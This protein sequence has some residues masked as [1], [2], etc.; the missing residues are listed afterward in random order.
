MKSLDINEKSNVAYC[1][2]TSLR[3]E[4]IKINITKVSERIQPHSAPRED[5]IAIV[6]YG[7]SL[8]DTW[9]EIKKFKYIMTCSGAHKFLIDRGIIPTWH[10]DLEPREYKVK[11]L[12]KPHSDV[13]YLIA[14]TVHPG[15][16]DA[17]AGYNVKLWHIFAN[18]GDAAS[19]LPRGE[20][21]VTGGCIHNLGKV[22]TEDGIKTIKQIVD[23]GYRGRVLSLNKDGKFVWSKILNGIVRRN[24]NP[25]KEWVRLITSTSKFKQ[26]LVC[27]FDHRCA[28]ID[29][30]LNPK[31]YYLEANK[32][33]GKYSVRLPD[34]QL[35][36]N[37]Q[38]P[39]YNNEQMSIMFGIMMG[40]GDIT[41]SY[42]FRT[43]HGY[44]QRDYL[45]LIHNIFGGKISEHISGFSKTPLT[46]LTSPANEQTKIL[47]ELF[48]PNNEIK[49]IKN[50]LQYLDEKSL[51]FWYMDDG[52]LNIPKSVHGHP[53]RG[54]IAKLCTQGFGEKDNIILSRYFKDR[55]GIKCSVSSYKRKEKNKREYFLTLSVD[56]SKRLFDLI[57]KYVPESMQY[58]LP[59]KHRVPFIYKFNNKK[60][61][62]A[63]SFIHDVKKLSNSKQKS[64][65]L[66]DLEVEETHSFVVNKTVVHNSSVGLRCM[67]LSR[68]LG[69]KDMH[70]FGMD[71]NFKEGGS[72]HTA[73]HPNAPKKE[74]FFIT[75]YKGHIYFTNPSLLHCAKETFH[76][77]NQMPDVKATFYGEGLTQAMAKDYVRTV[78]KN[79]PL[80]AF[81][82]PE[83]ISDEYRDLNRK[84]HMSNPTYG[85]GGSKHKDTILKLSKQLNTTSILDY[86]CGKGMLAKELQFPIWEYD[87]AVPEKSAEPK[88]ADIVVCTDVL[89][90]IEEDKLMFVLSD[91]K[92]CVKQVGYFVISTRKA[93]KTYANGKN[94][95]NIVKG[96]DWWNKQLGKY[97]DI[98]TIIE[99][100][101]ELQ[102][103]VGI[104]TK[105]T[106]VQ[107]NQIKE[108]EYQGEKVK[109]N[110]PNKTIEWRVD[111]LFKK[112]PITIEWLKSL[113]KGEILI[114]VGA[115]MG[116]YSMLASKAGVKVFAFEPEAENYALL[117]KNIVL[118]ES[119]AI[120]Y[121]A[122]VS[123]KTGVSKLS[124]SQ[125][126]VGGSCHTF[127]VDGKYN[128]G[129]VGLRLDDLN[130][131]AD[132]IK[133]DVDG[134]EP[135]VVAGAIKLLS[136]G[137]KSVLMEV[138]TNLQSHLAMIEVMKGMGYVYDQSQ[139]DAAIR[140]DGPFKGCAEYLF[141]KIVSAP[142]SDHIVN[143][144][145]NTV[146]ETEPFKYLYVENV[147]PMDVYEEI[148]KN[149]PEGEYM[150]IEKT[151][152]TRGYPKRF[153]AIPESPFWLNLNRQLKK[154]GILDRCLL[155]RF[156]IGYSEKYLIDL[157]LIRDEPGYSIPPHTDSLNKV[158]TVLF[159][160]PKDEGLIDEGTSLFTPKTKYFV[161]DTGKHYS[162]DD[163]DKVKTVMFKPN[164][165]LAFARTNDSF[166]GVEPTKS[167]RDVLLYN[168]NKTK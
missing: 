42:N 101:D 23:S 39:M 73:E 162:F 60:L 168:I 98:G 46:R 121:C 67:T 16:L 2:P 85:M 4:Q 82:K 65:N 141:K 166:H 26:K 153:T 55:W 92:R 28:V 138:N 102:I 93:V 5:S 61:D 19:V 136:N 95:H 75:E 45:D 14:S 12:G 125:L 117:Q 70:I 79:E 118:N 11:L 143:R 22:E 41:K 163:F 27:T 49:T 18:E 152:G 123:D 104:K 107:V 111:T 122:A 72:T 15:Y 103:V 36:G 151:R 37:R 150:E 113:K 13:E 159:Y 108:V 132:H 135:Q 7:P 24:D 56:G 130:I 156:G 29:N 133:I 127:G 6:C 64:S 134:C 97:F 43:V 32:T 78:I 86:G 99:K 87:P 44:K 25:R 167:V 76:E 21:T 84:L 9:E 81:E 129:C 89:E 51:A 30:I 114:D 10:V 1:I 74:N 58:K 161:C 157:L 54:A 52:Y 38:N 71:G 33:K 110:V 164:S 48:Y 109:F 119:D 139:V 140:K 149:L 20:W 124:L 145:N 3:D 90:H 126:G 53:N 91:L 165:M 47:R 96:K 154:A 106:E 155:N 35:H 160:L 66:Y 144:V 115:N 83:L 62:Y 131:K 8:N 77:L 112:E 137:V 80:I 158:I 120:A 116:G 88:P 69:F 68:F 100:K 147:F 34:N 94:T 40:D 142:I 50:V 63:V 128:Q 57:A 17:L 31:I 59:E 105:Q 146:M 148:I